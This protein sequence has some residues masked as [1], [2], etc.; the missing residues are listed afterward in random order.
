MNVFDPGLQPE[1]TE[2]AWRRTTLAI[3]LGSL[4]SLRLLP[5]VFGHAL[6]VIPGC[7]GLVLCGLIWV[8]SRRRFHRI[9]RTLIAGGVLHAENGAALA[10][11]GA[12]VAAIGLAALGLAL[13]LA[14]M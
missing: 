4:V 10:A 6:W 12:F 11:L 2:L 7:L 14:W 9:S 13:A 3:A 8:G 1:R 5:D